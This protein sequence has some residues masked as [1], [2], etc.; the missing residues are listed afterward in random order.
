MQEKLHP[1]VQ[2]ALVRLSHLACF[3][4][5]VFAMA[6]LGFM[7]NLST[8]SPSLVP[9]LHQLH[10]FSNHFSGWKPTVTTYSYTFTFLCISSSLIFVSQSHKVWTLIVSSFSSHPSPYMLLTTYFSSD[11]HSCFLN[12]TTTIILSVLPSSIFP[13]AL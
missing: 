10:P 12:F 3:E 7:A 1:E 9:L 5:A 2:I 6:P 4:T 13:F 11:N 8:P